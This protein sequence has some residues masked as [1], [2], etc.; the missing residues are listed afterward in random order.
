MLNI[1][2]IRF[3]AQDV[4]TA[5]TITVTVFPKCTN[6]N[7]HNI[8]FNKIDGVWQSACSECGHTE[9]EIKNGIVITK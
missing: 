6:P 2:L 8:A 3:E 5:S 9:N 1:E 7:G 4:I